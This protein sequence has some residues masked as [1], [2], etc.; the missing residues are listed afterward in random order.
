MSSFS[1][2]TTLKLERPTLVAEILA[3]VRAHPLFVFAFVNSESQIEA[4]FR[5]NGEYVDI[6]LYGVSQEVVDLVFPLATPEKP[7]PEAFV[8]TVFGRS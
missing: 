6:P 2:T 4:F 7:L 3:S 5:F 8:N 1:R